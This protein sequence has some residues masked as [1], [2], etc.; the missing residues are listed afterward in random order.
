MKEFFYIVFSII[1]EYAM[2]FSHIYRGFHGDCCGT[3]K[4]CINL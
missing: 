1:Q 4:L 3:M 2:I